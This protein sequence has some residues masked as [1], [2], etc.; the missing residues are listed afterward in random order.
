MSRKPT[1]NDLGKKISELEWSKN[2][3]QRSEA[4]L[5]EGSFSGIIGRDPKMKDI[6]DMI[7]EISEAARF[8]GV[9]R[10]TLYRFLRSFP[11]IASN[12]FESD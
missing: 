4:R 8:L 9:G 7:K 3:I 2:A 12:I 10:A 1:Y 6:F 11:N 5:K